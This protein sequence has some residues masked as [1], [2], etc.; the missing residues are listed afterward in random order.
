MYYYELIKQVTN[1]YDGNPLRVVGF[2]RVFTDEAKTVALT[3]LPF[4]A[5]GINESQLLVSN[6]PHSTAEEFN[7]AIEAIIMPLV[8]SAE[9][10][11]KLDEIKTLKDLGLV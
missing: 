1:I 4:N 2:V 11:A 7:S 9:I 5:L 10:Q 3:E 8:D 6:L